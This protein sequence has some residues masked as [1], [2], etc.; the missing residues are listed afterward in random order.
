MEQKCYTSPLSVILKCFLELVLLTCKALLMTCGQ[1]GS[2]RHLSSQLWW[3]DEGSR[4]PVTWS[5]QCC[6]RTVWRRQEG[7][8]ETSTRWDHPAATTQ[9]G[10]L[11]SL[12]LTFFNLFLSQINW[13]EKGFPF[14]SGT[15]V[16]ELTCSPGTRGSSK[17]EV[18]AGS[19]SNWGQLRDQVS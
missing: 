11:F 5:A 13:S 14:F 2:M 9:G 8:S 12:V 16:P 4:G 7:A 6:P 15:D 19:M 1:A 17:L 18:V 3:H 10:C